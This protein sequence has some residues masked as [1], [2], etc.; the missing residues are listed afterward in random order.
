MAFMTHPHVWTARHRS[1]E[2]DRVFRGRLSQGAA[3]AE[4]HGGPT[5]TQVW[6]WAESVLLSGCGP[7]ASSF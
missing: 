5:D 1:P 7:A 3:S 4:G 2:P 6:N